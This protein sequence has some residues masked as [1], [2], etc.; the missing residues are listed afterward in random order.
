MKSSFVSGGESL[1]LFELT[2]LPMFLVRADTGSIVAA[3]AH[4]RCLFEL[5]STQVEGKTSIDLGIWEHPQDRSRLMYQIKG[6]GFVRDEK[7]NMRTA[8]GCPLNVSITIESI[9]IAGAPCLLACFSDLSMRDNLMDRLH[10]SQNQLELSAGGSLFGSWRLSSDRNFIFLSN[11]G[12]IVLNPASTLD[13]GFGMNLSDLMHPEDLPGFQ[14]AVAATDLGTRFLDLP[15]RLRAGGGHYRWF[16]LWSSSPYTRGGIEDIHN[17]KTLEIDKLRAA[18]QVAL[19]TSAAHMG[20]FEVFPDGAAVWDPQMYRLYGHDPGTTLLPKEIFES[21]QTAAGLARTSRWI[22]KSL[23][24]GLSVEIEFEIRWPDGQVR[25]LASQGG[26]SPASELS[27]PSLIGV[28]WDITSQH[29]AK[30][31]LQK[32][33]EDLSR[34]TGQLLNQEK[35]TTSRVAQALH[36]QLG[37]TLTAARLIA[38]AQM[39]KQPSEAGKKIVM[40]MSQAMQ[41]VR[42]LLMDL[43]PPM[44][45]D[46]GLGPALQNEIDRM[47]N[48]EN[49][50]DITLDTDE[51]FLTQ[52]WP[53]EVEY[54]YFMIAREAISNALSHA[55][56]SLIQVSLHTA[57]D[58]LRMEIQDDGLGFEIASRAGLSGHLGLVGMRER[59]SAIQARLSFHSIDG[60]GTQVKLMWSPVQ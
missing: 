56:P 7:V 30:V 51:D 47:M 32:H 22:G 29:R 55:K 59:A 15:V 36:D 45:E 34:L 17:H 57:H 14:M 16:H 2:P 5:G 40:L 46:S 35:L 19:A 3:N 1:Q 6:K 49:N 50:C 43:R 31:L 52:R 38:D 21:V 28:T 10:Y 25:W 24:Y 44:L 41:Q 33:Q 42:T 39:Q 8:Q 53:S 23:K 13:Q 20:I 60:L 54:A 4:A 48:P 26:F 18:Q 37:Q 11:R 12:H 58:G 27:R 9:T